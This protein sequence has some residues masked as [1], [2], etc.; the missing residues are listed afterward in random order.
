M[1]RIR[2]VVFVSARPDRR[3]THWGD[4]A[5]WM[6]VPASRLLRR[7]QPFERSWHHRRD[8]RRR[9]GLTTP[10]NMPAAGPAGW[11]YTLGRDFYPT[12]CR[13]WRAR[14]GFRV[15]ISAANRAAGPR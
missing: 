4:W 11:R 15:G 8:V 12:P 10:P 7:L 14:P 9:S 2:C 3:D 1:S 13:A 5:D 6:G